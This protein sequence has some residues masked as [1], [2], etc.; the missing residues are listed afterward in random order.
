MF[1]KFLP[2]RFDFNEDGLGMLNPRTGRRWIYASSGKSSIY[3]ILKAYGI[4]K[5]M[6]PTYICSSVLKP[7]SDLNVAVEFYD[8]DIEDLNPSFQS[9]MKLITKD[10]DAVLVSS[11]YGNPA[12]LGKFEEYCFKNGIVL[13]DDAAQSFGAVL[14]DRPVGTFGNCGFFSF[15]PGKPLAGHM[16]SFFWT[17]KPYSF[18]PRDN[19][20]IHYMRWLEYKKGRL[21][22][23]KPGSR[24]IGEF[25]KAV[26][27]IDD[28]IAPKYED[29]IS[30]FERKILGGI[31][32][33]HFKGEFDFR[34]NYVEKLYSKMRQTRV[35]VVK[36]I[37]GE[38]NPHKII[39]VAR[40]QNIAKNFK[41]NLRENAIY[42]ING[43]SL[44]SKDEDRMPIASG[45]DKLIFEIPI[46]NNEPKMQWLIDTI[47]EFDNDTINK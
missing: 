17:D 37:R 21:E 30:E 24:I 28:T 33:S 16:G 19:T 35:R 34:G 36:N 41:N 2:P 6:V 5:I 10:I 4:R 32:C 8:I 44:L 38:G 1:R 39:L 46:E 13:I 3:H 42:F 22:I 15:S 7:I 47:V 14:D 43:Y 11:M 18:P 9:L 31:L 27:T 25:L 23:Y 26:R 40:D 29:G 20:A 12:D 45:V